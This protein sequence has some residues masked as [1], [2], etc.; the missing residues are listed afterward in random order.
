MK[1]AGLILLA[2]LLL[3][4][5]AFSGFYYFGTASCRAMMSEPQP[6][7]AWLKKEFKL[8]DTEVARITRLHEA[9]L[10]QCA[11]HCTRIAELND[12]LEQLLSQASSVTPEIQSVLSERAKVRADCEAE[13]LSHFLE[14]S[15]MMPPQQGQRYLEWVEQQTCLGGQGMEAR[16]HSME[17][18]HH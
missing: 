13:M 10:P 7:L 15:R 1:K 6:E 9:Y 3:S 2:G 18:H 4:T 8:S 17:G 5:A 11:Q 12:K 14:V 16:H